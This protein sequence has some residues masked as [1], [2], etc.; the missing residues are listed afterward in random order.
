MK[1]AIP[2]HGSV[3]FTISTLSDCDDADAFTFAFAC[4]VNVGAASLKFHMPAMG[5]TNWPPPSYSPL[6]ELFYFNSTQGYGI[7]YLYDTSDKPQGYGGGGGGNFDSSSAL[8]AMD[9]RTGAIKWKHEH[10]SGGPG[11]AAE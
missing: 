6:T 2:V 1:A 5:A 8:M 7:A 11:A 3:I 10:R 4:A 9:I